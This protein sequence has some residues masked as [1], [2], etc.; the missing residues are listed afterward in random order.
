[1]PG[2]KLMSFQCPANAY[3]GGIQS[4]FDFNADDRA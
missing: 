2:D 3:I 1:M 4:N